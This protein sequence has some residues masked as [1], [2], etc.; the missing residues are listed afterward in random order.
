MKS[1]LN[2][3]RKIL[4]PKDL[5]PANIF[6]WLLLEAF[7][8]LQPELSEEQFDAYF[9]SGKL[10]G[11][12]FSYVLDPNGS[13]I[14]MYV[15]SFFKNERNKVFARTITSV[16]KNHRACKNYQHAEME[17][18]YTRFSIRRLFRPYVITSY[19]VSPIIFSN[20]CR[21]NYYCRFKPFPTKEQLEF[22]KDYSVAEL[23]EMGKVREA[24]EAPAPFVFGVPFQ[25]DFDE[26]LKQR[27]LTTE[28]YFIKWFCYW[29]AGEFLNQKAI[30]V[31]IPVN[32]ICIIKRY[33][34]KLK[35]FRF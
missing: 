6:Y 20:L 3:Q 15:A 35:G 13:I 11:V 30:L 22:I 24:A 1:L 12:D 21:K 31:E 18:K 7:R 14:S 28:D 33:F 26:A 2:I 29:T 25:V 9:K 4:K 10:L 16:D 27:I 8:L 19:V 34:I 23:I 17:R 32:L 5:T